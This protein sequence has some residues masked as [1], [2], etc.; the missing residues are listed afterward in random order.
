MSSLTG[1]AGGESFYNVYT[2]QILMVSTLNSL[3]SYLSMRKQSPLSSSPRPPDLES[4]LHLESPHCV[5]DQLESVKEMRISFI[6]GIGGLE[7]P[8]GEVPL[9]EPGRFR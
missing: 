2:E 8:S 1:S 7:T 3:Q 5:K 4:H 6:V 9:K